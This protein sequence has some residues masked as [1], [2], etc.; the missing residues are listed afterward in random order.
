MFRTLFATTMLMATFTEA[1][2][3]WGACP[4]VE[5]MYDIDMEAYSGKWYIVKRDDSKNPMYTSRCPIKEILS[6]GD[7][8]ASV[9]VG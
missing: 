1:K 4:K 6:H 2:I 5:A 3:G 9:H 8:K 7:G